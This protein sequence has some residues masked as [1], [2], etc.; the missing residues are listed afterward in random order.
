MVFDGFVSFGG[1][2]IK[3]RLIFFDSPS[4]NGVGRFVN[5]DDNGRFTAVLPAAAIYGVEAIPFDQPKA[6]ISLGDVELL[7]SAQPIHLEIPDG[8][9]V[10]RVKDRGNPV[11]GIDVHAVLHRTSVSGSVMQVVKTASTDAAGEARFESLLDGI[12]VVEASNDHGQ[13][14]ESAVTLAR[15]DLKRL[16]LGLEPSLELAGFVHDAKDHGIAGASVDCLFLSKANIPGSARAETNDE[17]HFSVVL[18]PLGRQLLNCG[19]S[20]LAGAIAAFTTPPTTTADFHLPADAGTLTISDWGIH[21]R[22]D[23]YWLVADD[24]RMF[25]LTWAAA[26]VRAL[27]S[28]LVIRALGEG[29]W[30]IVR[31]DTVDRWVR[32]GTAG[33]NALDP[34][35]SFRLKS[36][37]TK[38]VRL[39]EPTDGGSHL[40]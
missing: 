16:D 40:K 12:W 20:T 6:R 4:P 32:L 9:I 30:K 26:E 37:D 31:A 18:P 25:D 27:W 36:G 21:L 35:V 39:Y 24:G 7:D 22:L 8:G 10:V 23:V 1:K 17:G 15:N 2:G 13:S 33:G 29:S 28:P 38:S 14:A 5:A 11:S 34:I 3:A 19:V